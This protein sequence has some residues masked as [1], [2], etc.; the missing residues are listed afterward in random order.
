MANV[1]LR[2]P[3]LCDNIFRVWTCVCDRI[4]LQLRRFI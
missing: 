3:G 4:K 2:R 1:C